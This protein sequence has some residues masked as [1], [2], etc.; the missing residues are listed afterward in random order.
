MMSTD[1]CR[2]GI[3]RFPIAPWL[4]RSE[5]TDGLSF[6]QSSPHK[7]MVS[8]VFNCPVY[9]YLIYLPAPGYSQ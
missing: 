2:I 5:Y 7:E 4:R 9:T 3:T 6:A 1:R 8:S